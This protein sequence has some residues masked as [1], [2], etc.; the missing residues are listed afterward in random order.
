MDWLTSLLTWL[1]A[2]AVIAVAA[3][4]LLLVWIFFRYVGIIM[5]IF[6][7]KPIFIIPRGEPLP[8]AEDVTFPT[9]DGLLLCGSYLRTGRPRRRGV[10]LF[11]TEFGSNRWSCY[12]Y[13][14][15][16]LA[17]G[18]DI[19]TF[20]FRNCGDS[21]GLPDYE[22]LQWVTDYEVEDVRSAIRYL[23]SRADA[24]PRGIGFFGVSRGGSAG[25]IAAA[26]EPYIRCVVT[27]GAFATISTMVPYMQKWVSLYSLRWNMYRYFPRWIYVLAA[28]MA[29]W[30]LSRQRRCQFPSLERAIAQIAPRPLLMIHGGNDTYIRPE[31]ARELFARAGQPKE[32]W[33]VEG[34]K[35]NQAVQ[36]AGEEYQERICQFFLTHLGGGRKT[37]LDLPQPVETG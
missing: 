35:H 9:R 12:P 21:E 36:I 31:W 18:F 5:R 25:L 16:L 17:A 20:E 22:P 15:G 24:D 28:Q 30:R 14:R 2:S 19:F 32:L 34:A 13:C 4:A 29:L 1:L 3:F 7:E 8:E 10:I 11:G 6:Q 23:R 37:R 27:D 33:I 26:S